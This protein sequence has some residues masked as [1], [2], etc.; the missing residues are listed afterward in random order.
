MWPFTQ[1]FPWGRIVLS[2]CWL[3]YLRIIPDSDTLAIIRSSAAHHWLEM[4][5]K[6]AESSTQNISSKNKEEANDIQWISDET[7]L[8]GWFENSPEVK[9]SQIFIW[10]RFLEREIR[11]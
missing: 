5:Q 7:D 3:I 8:N 4:K 11:F 1:F 9:I 10:L 2:V 6:L